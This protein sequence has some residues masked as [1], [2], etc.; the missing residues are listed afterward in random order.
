MSI[1]EFAQDELKDRTIYKEL[2]EMERDEDLKE[3]L[4]H[5]SQHE[6]DHYEF[7]LTQTEKRDFE[8]NRLR[9]W[10]YKLLRMLFGLTFTL[11]LL[12][13]HERDVIDS[14]RRYLDQVEGEERERWEQLIEEEEEHEE[15]LIGEVEE[16]RVRYTGAIIL[17]LN[18]GL[19]ELTG[20]LAGLTA[21][22]Q[23]SLIVAASGLITGIA[24]SMSMAASS[25]LQARQEHRDPQKS[26]V[27]TGLSYI[28]VVILLVFPFFVMPDLNVALMSTVVLAVT[29]VVFTSFYLSVLFERSFRTEVARMFVFS[30]GIALIAFLIGSVVN[31]LFGLQV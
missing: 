9:V 22:L 10:W 8:V 2:A 25:Y 3:I 23:N 26:A 16:E 12:E 19:V 24:A 17:G 14:Y 20:A 29:V 30:L 13:R 5:L 27:Y 1:E 7:F 18:D 15:R 4:E 31:S 6:S 11:K 28:G 21:A